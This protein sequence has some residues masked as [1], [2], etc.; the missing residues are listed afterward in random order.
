MSKR[1]AR[2]ELVP[3]TVSVNTTLL[4]APSQRPHFLRL[5]AANGETL[6]H[7]EN[8]STRS[9][10]RRASLAWVAAFRDV[11]AAPATERVNEVTR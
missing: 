4:L 2:I 8:Y 10:A 9:N 3:A 7:T 11:L 5:V 6:A 1:T